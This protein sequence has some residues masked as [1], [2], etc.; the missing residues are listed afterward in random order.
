[1]RSLG[2]KTDERGSLGRIFERVRWTKKR[3]D[4]CAAVKFFKVA[5]TTV[6][7]NLGT[8]SWASRVRPVDETA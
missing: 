2:Y 5:L 7:K 3:K 4:S 6:K 1:M 8:A